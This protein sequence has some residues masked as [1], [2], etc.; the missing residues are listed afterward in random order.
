MP[1]SSPHPLHSGTL[2]LSLCSTGDVHAGPTVGKRKLGGL[3][4]I[5]S[6]T[7]SP[8]ESSGPYTKNEACGGGV[9]SSMI[10]VRD[11]RHAYDGQTVLELPA[12]DVEDGEHLLLLG[13]SGSGKTT[14]LHILAGLL[15]P[16]E[17]MVAVDDR[18]LTAMPEADRDRWRGANVGVVFQRLH[19]FETL[20]VAQNLAL[21]QRLATGSTHPARTSELL[22]RLDVAGKADAY[23][24]S[25]STGQRQ[26]VVIA[27]AVGHRPSLLLAD[28]PT[29]SLDDDR[30]QTVAD[31]LVREATA[32]GATLVVATHDRRIADRFDRVLAL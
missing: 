6:S 19:L 9:F 10:H 26:R 3:R 20:T 18:D 25:L 15:R 21:A 13:A 24:A 30:A 14:L 28:E 5:K 31:L 8:M 2:R 17:G 11:L 23:P 16:T 22:S 32:V 1:L 29:A 27:R 7:S 4:S 12:L